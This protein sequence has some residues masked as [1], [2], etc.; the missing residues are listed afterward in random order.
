MLETKKARPLGLAFLICILFVYSFVCL[1]II[2][3]FELMEK[4]LRAK[5]EQFEADVDRLETQRDKAL[6]HK[7]QLQLQ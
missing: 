3:K 4:D 7:T 5:I 1:K 2:S 6:V